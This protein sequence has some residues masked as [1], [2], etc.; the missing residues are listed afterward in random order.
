M[1]TIKK[2]KQ[3][4]LLLV[5]LVVL[6]ACK[7]ENDSDEPQIDSSLPDAY[8]KFYNVD[9]V[10][11]EGDFVVIECEGIPDHKSPYYDHTAWENEKYEAYAG[12]NT[13]YHQNPNKIGVQNFTFRIPLN[14]AEDVVH[15]A[16][17]MGPIGVALNGVAIFNQYAAPGDD[18]AEE[19][20]TFDHYNGHPTGTDT[21]H[22]HIEPTYLTSILGANA[23]IG[24]L[25]DGFP[26]YGP[27]E[28]GALITNEDLDAYHGHTHAT[29]EFPAG[30]YHYHITS[31]D[32][33]INGDGFY[34][35]AGTVTQ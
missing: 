35:T 26:V 28:D 12:S 19:I 17:P 2:L 25:L 5:G 10:Y 23:L 22:Y 27:M 15:S 21:Y 11:Q 33:Y 31:E 1:H 7:K 20:N 4:T 29:A 24:F 3:T 6:F 30:I 14:P 8:Q 34:G 13:G 18:L 32:P 9:A 16:T